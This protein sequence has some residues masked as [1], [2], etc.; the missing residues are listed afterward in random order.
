MKRCKIQIAVTQRPHGVEIRG[1]QSS[2]FP[3]FRIF[4]LPAGCWCTSSRRGTRCQCLATGASSRSTCRTSEASRSRPSTCPTSSRTGISGD[5]TRLANPVL[6]TGLATPSGTASS[7]LGQ[8]LE[9]PESLELRKRRIEADMEGGEMPSLPGHAS[10]DGA[11]PGGHRVET[12]AIR[13]G[14]EACL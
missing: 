5:G 1:T 9:K 12:M 7:V 3:Y 11:Q 6:E 10:R 8:G 14:D 2:V 13:S 4:K